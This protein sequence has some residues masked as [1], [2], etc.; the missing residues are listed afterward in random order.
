MPSL[1]LKKEVS[2]D[3]RGGPIKTPRLDAKTII[4][5][6]KKFQDYDLGGHNPLHDVRYAMG[7]GMSNNFNQLDLNKKIVSFA[8]NRNSVS[9]KS[10]RTMIMNDHRGS[11]VTSSA[12]R[13]EITRGFHERTVKMGINQPFKI[14]SLDY[15]SKKKGL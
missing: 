14:N 10:N 8:K 12:R 6:A 7:S 11:H 1:G 3:L 9:I 4:S 2:F 13:D 15:E 5:Q